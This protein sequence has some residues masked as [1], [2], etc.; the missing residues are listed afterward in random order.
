M[1]INNHAFIENQ[2][3]NNLDLLT[4]MLPLI[5]EYKSSDVL[6]ERTK[7]IHDSMMLEAFD[8]LDIS[9]EDNY[10]DEIWKKFINK[11]LTKSNKNPSDNLSTL[12]DEVFLSS[13]YTKLVDQYIN[14]KFKEVG[15]DDYAY[16][17]AKCTKTNLEQKMYDQ[18]CIMFKIESNT[19]RHLPNHVSDI[20]NR[21]IPL[22]ES[23]LKMIK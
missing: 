17:R 5:E 10:E 22:I 18:F 16:D 21:F 4:G 15:L 14:V 19:N 11:Q 9:Y 13:K 1:G 3:K 6:I 23:T 12:S 2:I 7:R 20:A 8:V